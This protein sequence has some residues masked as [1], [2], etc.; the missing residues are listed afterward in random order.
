MSDAPIPFIAYF[1]ITVTA[2]TLAYATYTDEGDNQGTVTE[3][4]D[5]DSKEDNQELSNTNEEEVMKNESEEKTN[6][7]AEEQNIPPVEQQG[8]MPNILQGPPP[9][10]AVETQPIQSNNV[11]PQT[12]P[13]QS[14]SNPFQKEQIDQPNKQE[15]KSI[16]DGFGFG[17]KKGGKS[18]KNRKNIKNTSKRNKK[19]VAFAG[20]ETSIKKMRQILKEYRKNLKNKMKN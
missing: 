4:E 3:K 8:V 14:L 10:P 9:P 20:N 2:G 12:E 1:F 7:E 16:F 5:E 6:I 19:N 15:N 11:Q 18:K 13:V 17:T